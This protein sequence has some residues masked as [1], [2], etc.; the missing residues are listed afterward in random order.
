[1]IEAA[2]RGE[3]QRVAESCKANLKEFFSYINSRKPVRNKIDPLHD[4]GGTLQNT[5]F[6]MADILST[7]F[8]SVFTEEEERAIPKP[9][10]VHEG[11]YMENIQRKGEVPRDWREAN[12][13][14]IFKKGDLK[15]SNKVQHRRLMPKVRA[16]GIRGA[17]FNWIKDRRHRVVISGAKFF[18]DTKLGIN[19]ATFE[20]VEILRSDLEKVGNWS[21]KCLLPFDLDKSKIIHIGYANQRTDSLLGHGM[22]TLCYGNRTALSPVVITSEMLLVDDQTLVTPL[23]YS[24]HIS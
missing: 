21:E 8:S 24:Y 17:V 22:A 5:D 7:Q 19:V 3:E 16:M 23:S 20:R 13:T 1:M 2:K 15:A 14:P 12:V 10:L 6:K 9:V 18:D 4:C 11:E